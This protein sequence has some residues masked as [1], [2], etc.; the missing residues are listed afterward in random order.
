MMLKYKC[1]NIETGQEYIGEFNESHH[2][3]F[4]EPDSVPVK[5]LNRVA[6]DLFHK[7]NSQQPKT[8]QYSRF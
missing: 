2:W 1:I 5:L 4:Q 8:W 7:W 6:D 3:C